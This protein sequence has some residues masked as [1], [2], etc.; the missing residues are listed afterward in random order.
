MKELRLPDEYV[1]EYERQT[2]VYSRAEEFLG[3]DLAESDEYGFKR[4]LTGVSLG[5]I[6]DVLTGQNFNIFTWWTPSADKAVGYMLRALPHSPA[7]QRSMGRLGFLD[8]LYEI[9]PQ[10]LK[11]LSENKK[12][13]P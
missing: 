5:V 12:Y 9:F 1:R 11:N 2:A 10:R 6:A 8:R 4:L 13:Y 3:R 7:V